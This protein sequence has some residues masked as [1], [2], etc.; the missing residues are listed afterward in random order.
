MSQ[1]FKDLQSSLL[2][3]QQ[4][5]TA[6]QRAIQRELPDLET[7][8]QRERQACL[9]RMSRAIRTARD[10]GEY[11]IDAA[12]SRAWSSITAQLEDQNDD[13]DLKRFMDYSVGSIIDDEIS[14][15]RTKLDK[16][17]SSMQREMQS[18]VSDASQHFRQAYQRLAT[19]AQINLSLVTTLNSSDINLNAGTTFSDLSTMT[20]EFASDDNWKLLGGAGIGAVVGTFIAPGFGTVIGAVLGGWLGSMFISAESKR[21]TLRSKLQPEVEQFFSRV[22]EQFKQA[23]NTY[24]RTTLTLIDQ[25]INAHVARNKAV[26][27]TVNQQQR[28]EAEKLQALQQA[29]NADL[30]QITTYQSTL[31][32]N[33]QELAQHTFS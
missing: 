27:A 28:Q 26:V 15:L 21:A 9:Q 11:E 33:R 19:V 29:V 14:T 13:D 18:T 16:A 8:A 23:I 5:Y 4:S 3:H 20:A 22:Q 6:R 17:A 7:L 1:L 2:A 25:Q 32:Q 30:A 10:E 31:E 12:S 24:E